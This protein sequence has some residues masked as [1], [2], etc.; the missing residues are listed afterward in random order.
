VNSIP[1]SRRIIA[2][3]YVARCEGSA[4]SGQLRQDLYYRLQVNVIEVPPLRERLADVALLAEHFIA[5]FNWRLTR[6][7]PITGIEPE[8]L[9]AMGRHGWPGNVRELSNAIESAF[10]FGT[11]DTLGLT[12]LP[13]AVSGVAR[14]SDPPHAS[15][16]PAAAATLSFAETER[17]L[18]NRA[19]ASTGGNKYR[20]AK[21]LGISR[22]R[23]YARLR[24]Y[25][26]G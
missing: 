3:P 15:R 16:A 11:S 4:C 25:E 13:A 19:L 12:D 14:N 26:L 20:A 2:V 9:D 22:K 5:L 7:G 21:L 23:L 17:D 10:T 1:T 18:I 6:I 8:A 24:R